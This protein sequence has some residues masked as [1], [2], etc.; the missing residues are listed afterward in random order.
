MTANA[1]MAESRAKAQQRAAVRAVLADPQA[2]AEIVNDPAVRRMVAE[3]VAAERARQ[4]AADARQRQQ[5]AAARAAE[6]AP[7]QTSTK[8]DP[9]AGQPDH[10][11]EVMAALMRNAPA[12]EVNRLIRVKRAEQ[13]RARGANAER[14]GSMWRL[15]NG[16]MLLSDN[17]KTFPGTGQGLPPQQGQQRSTP[18]Q[19]NAAFSEQPDRLIPD[20]GDVLLAAADRALPSIPDS[21]RAS[22]D[23]E[24]DDQ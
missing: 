23:Q 2:R 24:E 18:L 15:R 12:A 9:W 3:E 13:D 21:Q 1:R 5:E 4:E 6:F 19:G 14:A 10:D 8:A 17:A 11:P 16:D 20:A 7:K 22:A